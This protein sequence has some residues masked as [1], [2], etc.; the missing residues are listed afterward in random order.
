MRRSISPIQRHIRKGRRINSAG[1]LV[2][3]HLHALRNLK[4]IFKLDPQSRMMFDENDLPTAVRRWL[5][6]P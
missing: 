2:Q 3:S 5:I 1:Y 6:G 4:R